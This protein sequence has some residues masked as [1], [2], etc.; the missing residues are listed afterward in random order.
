MEKEQHQNHGLVSEYKYNLSDRKIWRSFSE[1][2]MRSFAYL[3]SLWF[4]LYRNAKCKDKVLSWINKEHIF[5]KEYV[6]VPIVCW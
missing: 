2:R 4:S 5:T 3:D 1:D 6:F